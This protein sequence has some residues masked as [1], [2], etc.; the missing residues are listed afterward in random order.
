MP[1]LRSRQRVGLIRSL[2]TRVSETLTAT[3][4][5]LFSLLTCPPT[6][7]FTLLSIFFPLEM[8][9]IKV[10][11]TMRSLLAKCSLPVAVRVSKT[12]VLKLPN[13]KVVSSILTPDRRWRIFDLLAEIFFFLFRF[14]VFISMKQNGIYF[15]RSLRLKI[16]L[17]ILFL[18]RFS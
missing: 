17:K 3:G 4:S 8:S 6:T 18:S 14:S 9:S 16:V 7:T 10:W 2:S 11:E 5:E 12:R 13:P 1:R 15:Q